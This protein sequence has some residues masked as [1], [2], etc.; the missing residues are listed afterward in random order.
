MLT[1]KTAKFTGSFLGDEEACPLFYRE[2]AYLEQALRI[3][4]RRTLLTSLPGPSRYGSAVSPFRRCA[5][6]LTKFFA[7]R[8]FLL[9]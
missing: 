4:L 9:N 5:L 2:S 1:K 8:I 6:W 7:R 3:C